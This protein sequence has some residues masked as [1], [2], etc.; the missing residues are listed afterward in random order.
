MMHVECPWCGGP[1]A[2]E[3]AGDGEFSCTDCSIS[4]ELAPEPIADTVALAA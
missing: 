3:V 4:V 1:A 2:V